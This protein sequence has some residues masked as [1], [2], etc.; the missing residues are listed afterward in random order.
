MNKSDNTSGPD[1]QTRSSFKAQGQEHS[2]FNNQRQKRSSA[3]ASQPIK[4]VKAN[5]Y[6]DSRDKSSD[7]SDESPTGEGKRKKKIHASVPRDSAVSI[8]RLTKALSEK[9]LLKRREKQNEPPSKVSGKN[10]QV[11]EGRE[12][13]VRNTSTVASRSKQFSSLPRDSLQIGSSESDARESSDSDASRD[14]G[15]RKVKNTKDTIV[16]EV[17]SQRV[18]KKQ[19]KETNH[20]GSRSTEA[21]K[22]SSKIISNKVSTKKMLTR[23]NE[24][25]IPRSSQET[26]SATRKTVATIGDGPQSKGK[27]EGKGKSVMKDS[28]VRNIGQ[29]RKSESGSEDKDDEESKARKQQKGNKNRTTNSTK[30]RKSS[31]SEN[32]K[33]ELKARRQQKVTKNIAYSGTRK[34]SKKK[35]SGNDSESAS[36]GEISKKERSRNRSIGS[37]N[38]SRRISSSSESETESQTENILIQKQS[39]GNVKQMKQQEIG[40]RRKNVDKD[41]GSVRQNGDISSS[42]SDGFANNQRRATERG[43]KDNEKV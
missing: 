41:M 20:D 16:D 7:I 31:E 2:S 6:K 4:P 33:E 19:N 43:S 28:K 34:A 38:M 9:K 12:K 15:N 36:E 5:S 3:K 26:G 30:N 32:E 39:A 27:K 13:S 1:G 11:K 22:S 23:Q 29:K 8:D 40:V 37:I 14:V 18:N 17:K 35:S 21:E 24:I 42:D 25:N 10:E